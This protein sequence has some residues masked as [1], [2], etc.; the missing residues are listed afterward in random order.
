MLIGRQN[1]LW[2]FIKNS[3]FLSGKKKGKSAVVDVLKHFVLDTKDCRKRNKKL[4]EQ[5]KKQ[6]EQK[7]KKLNKSKM[8][9]SRKYF[10]NLINDAEKKI[11]KNQNLN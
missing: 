7:K 1:F 4:A 10:K 9:N 6:A 5:K 11:T 2:L 8:K 3:M